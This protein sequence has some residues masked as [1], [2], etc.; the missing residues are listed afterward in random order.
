MAKALKPEKKPEEELLGKFPD[1][2]LVDG[3]GAD[4]TGVD[5]A[6]ADDTGVDDAGTDDTDVGGADNNQAKV[7]TG[8]RDVVVLKGNT[9]RHNGHNYGELSKITMDKADAERVQAL[10]IAEDLQT[11]RAKSARSAV[12]VVISG[13]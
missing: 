6:G 2:L 4:D 5:G 8:F 3:A 1:E 10:G 7:D 9:I 11:F 13:G 12:G